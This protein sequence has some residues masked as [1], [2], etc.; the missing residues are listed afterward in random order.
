MDKGKKQMGRQMDR[1][2][3][4]QKCKKPPL[5][6]FDYM[7]ILFLVFLAL[8]IIIPF[9]NAVM[10][11]VVDASEASRN[12][13]ILFPK[14]FSLESYRFVLEHEY[15]LRG[16]VNSI[17][18]TVFGTL[19]SIVLTTLCAYALSKP[20]PGRVFI[21][22]ILVFSMYLYGGLVPYYLLVNGLGLKDTL[23]ACIIPLG[24]N[25]SYMIIMRRWFQQLPKET[26][27]AAYMDGANEAQILWHIAIPLSKPIIAAFVLF[28]AVDRW[29]EWWHG[30][31]FIDDI[32]KQ[33]L[34][35]ILRN[36][37]SDASTSA[38]MNAQSNTDYVVF[39]DGIKMAS[40]VL[41]MLPVIVGYPFIQK[42]FIRGLYKS[43]DAEK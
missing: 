22:Y 34:Q 15:L 7:N 10:V 9:Y 43:H 35:L 24:I 14:T 28:Y 8:V 11:S 40:I 21:I 29:N 23:L 25:F 5:E 12:N 39:S 1:K 13:I 17:I 42:Y 38:G 32:S 33:P 4:R 36:I 27:E 6:M 31:L 37:M 20:L 2:M 30:M 26:M 18:I 19:Y 3:S 16:Y 41:T